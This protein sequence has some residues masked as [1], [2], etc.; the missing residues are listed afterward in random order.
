MN[1]SS[2]EWPM[3]S[4]PWCSTI[5][6]RW[7]KQRI[8]AP[9]YDEAPAKYTDADLAADM[10]AL[11]VEE[12]QMMEE[13]I[14]GVSNTIPETDEFVTA[15]FNEM[16]TALDIIPDNEKVAWERAVFLRPSLATDTPL[17][18][19]FLRAARFDAVRA[20]ELLVFRY[21]TKLYLFGDELLIH[22]ITW[23]DLT[24]E[25]HSLVTSGFYQLIPDHDRTGRG[26]TY[27]RLCRWDVSNAKAFGRCS[28]YVLSAIDDYPEM[29]RK[30]VV[31]IGDF[32][33]KWKNSF[34]QVIQYIG[35]VKES[36]DNLPCHNATSHLLYDDPNANTFIQGIRAV[37]KKDH[38]LRHR[39]HYGSTMEIDYS[40]KSF[41][42]D[43]SDC[44]DVDSATG[45]MSLQG[46][47]E[48]IHRREKIDDEWRRAES[49]Y[50]DPAS[51]VA[52][53]PNQ[54]DVILGRNKKIAMVWPGNIAYNKLIEEQ[55]HHYIAVEGLD[56]IAKTSIAI[57]T[58]RILNSDY[59]A[60]F[61]S[62]KDT[63]WE[64]LDDV[65]AQ[66]KVSQALRNAA[67]ERKTASSG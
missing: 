36:T 62:R 57:Q 63:G 60:R 27:S 34:L 28:F 1:F 3:D 42:I 29:Q 31:S 65:E 22:R 32:R 56:R 43:L 21:K 49:P 44:L 5:V 24:P 58:L 54:Q 38:R 55:A 48:D 64:V 46:I 35:G 59:R 40:L 39:F 9:T 12:R 8:L 30:G 23:Q 6:N 2:E 20:A 37:L 19:V 4:Q 7:K 17:Y 18:L 33:G 41:G 14:H 15:K 66:R 45:P 52:L 61:L 47:E 16:K 10:N 26:I 67:R 51:R 25:E 13:D 50:R 11:T 53:F